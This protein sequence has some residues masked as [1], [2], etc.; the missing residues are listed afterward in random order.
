MDIKV[1]ASQVIL[2]STLLCSTFSNADSRLNNFFE[3]NRYTSRNHIYNVDESH[4]IAELPSSNIKLYYI[5]E[6]KDFGIYRGFIIRINDA[7]KYFRWEAVT[8]PSYAPK[9]GLADLNEDGNKE[10]VVHLCKGYD[11]EI[12]DEEI[13]VIK[14]SISI[15]DAFEE[16]LIEN[17]VTILKKNTEAKESREYFEITVKNKKFT[18]RK[19]G[20]LTPPYENVGVGF[21]EGNTNYEV[22]DGTLYARIRVG[23]GMIIIGEFI[24]KYKYQNRILQMESIDFVE[25]GRN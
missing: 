4:L 25:F 23:A 15:N 20:I 5:K 24:V 1:I 11:T 10:I 12:Y 13:H 22:K 7:K 18:V 16:T 14:Q 6:D 3:A 17:P 2:I 8:A 9:L 19:K 21:G